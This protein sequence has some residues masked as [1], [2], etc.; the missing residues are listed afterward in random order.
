MELKPEQLHPAVNIKQCP[1]CSGSNLQ[2]VL[3]LPQIPVLCNVIWD[4][5]EE[6]VA[7]PRGDVRLSFCRDC[8]HLYNQDFN[9]DQMIYDVQYEN[10]L[11]FSPKFQSY[12]NWLAK[13]LVDQYDLHGK[14]I[15]EIGSGKGDFLRLLCE[16]GGNVGTGFDPSYEPEDEEAHPAMSFIKEEYSRRFSN[17]QADFIC[18]RHTL[19]HLPQPA[20]FAQEL[21]HTIADRKRTVVFVEVP[22]L[23]YI[24]RDVAI[25]DIIYEH[26][27]Y[28]SANSLAALFSLNSFN[29][30]NVAEAFGG[31]FLYIEAIPRDTSRPAPNHPY[32]QTVDALANRVNH[33]GE[34]SQEKIRRWQS[35]LEQFASEGKRAVIW[36]AGSKGISF[37]NLVGSPEVIPYA[38]D[39]NP[40]KRGKYITGTG[41]QIV[42][43]ESL[44]DI[45]PDAIIVMNPIYRQEI[46]NTIAE[47]GIN[48]ELIPA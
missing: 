46:E 28:F 27:S 34:L 13:H 31:Q 15:V 40:R 5:K 12:A 25:W 35:R 7:A 26:F 37:L 3:D 43:P 11:H 42:P 10:S 44:R 2:P 45:N 1:V 41:Q 9:P 23:N 38:V 47:L 17:Y 4:T 8:G 33:F 6:A 29:V 19:E 16:L 24:L 21:R 39:I 30:L 20:L 32:T 18:S 22:N 48:P 36:G 14:T